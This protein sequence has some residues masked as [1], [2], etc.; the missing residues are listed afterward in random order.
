MLDLKHAVA[1]LIK[2]AATSIITGG[3]GGRPAGLIGAA[4]VALMLG[5]LYY[6]VFRGWLPAAI[7]DPSYGTFPAFVHMLAL[8]WLSIALL[9]QRR[10]TALSVILLLASAMSEW[11]FGIYDRNDILMSVAGCALGVASGSYW[12]RNVRVR[13]FA[14]GTSM[15]SGA[16][17]LFSAAL[18]TG[19]YCTSCLGNDFGNADPVYLSYQEL[20][21]SVAVEDP[22]EL[23]EI[24]RV[25]VYQSAVFPNRRAV[26]L[27]RENEGIHVLDNSNPRNPV[28]IAFI[29]IPG[30][31]E[32]SIRDDFLYA[33]SYVDLVTLDIS[34]PANV[35]EVDREIDIFPYDEYQNIPVDIYFD[36]DAVDQS[37]GVVVSYVRKN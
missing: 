11:L 30:N 18:T 7:P 3:K 2:R 17:L 16:L 6:V 34:D 8:S 29:S 5:G 12:L 24:K 15:I 21:S 4:G 20:R 9:G 33:D 37:R 28:N 32:I 10:G 35:R 23:G 26:F 13:I 31:T 27:N 19:S 14:A 25:Y 1:S 22:L 36:Y